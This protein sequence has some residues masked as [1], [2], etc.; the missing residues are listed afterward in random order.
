[1]QRNPEGDINNKYWLLH[2]VDYISGLL[3]TCLAL[4][5]ATLYK[6]VSVYNSL[7]MINDYLQTNAWNMQCQ[8]QTWFPDSNQLK[9]NL[10]M[11]LEEFK[12][13]LDLR[14]N[15]KLYM[16]S[17]YSLFSTVALAVILSVSF[18][19]HWLRRIMSDHISV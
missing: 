3:I 18:T 16:P 2:W 12:V 17:N 19:V 7:Q 14:N 11:Q 1:M 5:L 6:C 9:N 13:N 8:I 10:Q 15:K 4:A